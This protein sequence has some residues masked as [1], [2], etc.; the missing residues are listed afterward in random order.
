VIGHFGR[1]DT[2]QADALI[3]ASDH[4]SIR[5]AAAGDLLA[6]RLLLH[7]AAWMRRR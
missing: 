6:V 7:P 1:I 4:I 3:T 2:E 5:D